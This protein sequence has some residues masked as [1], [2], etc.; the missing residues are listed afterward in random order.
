MAH[1]NENWWRDGVFYQIYP[2]SFR[3]SNADGV[4]DLAGILQRLPYV[5]SL[6]VDAIF[7]DYPERF[8]GLS[9]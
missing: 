8:S 7:S 1:D 9:T 4:G 6:G 5:R 3:D 2:R